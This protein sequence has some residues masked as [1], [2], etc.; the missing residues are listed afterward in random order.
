M[1][2]PVR[3]PA[4]TNLHKDMLMLAKVRPFLV[5][6]PLLLAAPCRA[7][8]VIN[9]SDASVSINV[10][11]AQS[12]TITGMTTGDMAVPFLATITSVGS[13]QQISLLGPL[14][15]F[16]NPLNLNLPATRTASTLMTVEISIPGYVMV[17]PTF[18][19]LDIDAAASTNPPFAS[20]QDQITFLDPG[21]GIS[22]TPVVPT[23]YQIAGNQ[24]TAVLGPNIAN[25]STAA[26]VNVAMTGIASTIRYAYGPGPLDQLGQNQRHGISNIT[27]QALAIPE[28]GSA[29]LCPWA[30]IALAWAR[31]RRSSRS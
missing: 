28:P 27:I 22:Y 25:A 26:N 5:A 9:W 12:A 14:G 11:D 17:N 18:D 24:I 31:R 6:L 3:L 13:P 8:I 15:D 4:A 10:T 7:D 21:P 19:L 16:A 29:C 23:R 1:G 20:W 2:A 30:A